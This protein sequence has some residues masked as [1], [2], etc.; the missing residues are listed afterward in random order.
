MAGGP[1]NA[2]RGIIG[3]L[4][5]REHL[6]DRMP[7]PGGFTITTPATVHNSAG[8]A[9]EV[10]YGKGGKKKIRKVASSFK[11][12]ERRMTFEEA[13]EN[14]QKM[15]KYLK[16]YNKRKDEIWEEKELASFQDDCDVI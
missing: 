8:R 5:G 7:P 3:G 9:V 12:E 10:V 16:Q 2:W 6:Y 4:K 13:M 1:G 11:E 15:F 14:P